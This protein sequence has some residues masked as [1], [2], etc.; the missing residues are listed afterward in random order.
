MTQIEAV[1]ILDLPCVLFHTRHVPLSGWKDS[2]I[3][4]SS[5]RLFSFIDPHGSFVVHTAYWLRPNNPSFQFLM[6]R[7]VTLLVCCA[8]DGLPTQSTF[9]ISGIL[10]LLIHFTSTLSFVQHLIRL[11]DI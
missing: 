10:S 9:S 3:E 11:W 6:L 4:Y 2:E 1:H 7:S 8:S 5:R